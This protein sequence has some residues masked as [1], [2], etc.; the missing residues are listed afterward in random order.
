MWDLPLGAFEPKSSRQR[1][2]KI[3]DQITWETIGNYLSVLEAHPDGPQGG[4]ISAGARS[5][6]VLSPVP[7]DRGS[8]VRHIY[9]PDVREASSVALQPHHV[10]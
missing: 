10:R 7:R 5:S 4:Q 9:R 6:Y 1:N 3:P 2:A 8:H